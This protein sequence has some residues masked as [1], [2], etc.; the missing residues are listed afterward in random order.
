MMPYPCLGDSQP[1][2]PTLRP[3]LDSG[4][5]AWTFHATWETAHKEN[6]TR[7]TNKPLAGCCAKA[8][9][10][11]VCLQEEYCPSLGR[12]VP[13]AI[14]LWSGLGAAD[15]P[16]IH[17]PDVCVPRR[18]ESVSGP[19]PRAARDLRW[20]PAAAAAAAPGWAGRHLVT[21]APLP[22]FT[23]P[24]VRLPRWLCAAPALAR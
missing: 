19:A 11:A 8:V 3:H 24:P 6:W 21:G 17:P 20:P 13:G 7:V 10:F 15:E 12:N 14:G 5:S 2:I 1:G 9:D 18:C 23:A 16:G 22:V 4:A